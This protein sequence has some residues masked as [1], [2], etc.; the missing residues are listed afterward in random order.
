M[1]TIVTRAGKGAALTWAE[2]DANF[3]NLNTAKIESENA[4]TEGQILSK[5]ASGAV[6]AD[7][8]TGGISAVV[9]D[10]APQLGGNLDVNAFSIV[11][12]AGG[13]INIIPGTGGRL[14]LSNIRYN[15]GTPYPVEFFDPLVVDASDGN[16]QEVTLTGNTT[17]NSLSNPVAGQSLTLIIKQDATG[18]RTLS[19]TMK[20]AGGEKTLS[21]A[22][23]AVDI[24][25]VFFD[26][27]NYWASLG[28]DF[29]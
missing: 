6:W 15:E 28:K 17:L 18:S 12:V 14:V 11:S 20:F 2:G 8:A 27:T 7:P 26:G 21:T 1:A 3:E 25:S 13:D 9:N 19:S 16:V 29:K 22:A 5:S 24:L 23:N 10:A 4:G